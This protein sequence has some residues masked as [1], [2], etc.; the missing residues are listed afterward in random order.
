MHRILL[1]VRVI[2]G[3]P[4]GYCREIELPFVPTVGMRF[5][6]GI[7]TTLWE[8]TSGDELSPAV[9]QVIYDLDEEMF[10][11]LFTVESPLAASFWENLPELQ[12]GHVCGVMDY[13]RHQGQ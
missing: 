12:P 5:E 11:C 8:T 10:V 7:S 1:A 6:Q 13:F 2:G 4:R 9:E 3:E